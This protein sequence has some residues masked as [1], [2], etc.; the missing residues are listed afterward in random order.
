VN[1]FDCNKPNGFVV[2]AGQLDYSSRQLPTRIIVKDG[3]HAGLPTG[4]ALAGLNLILVNG[5]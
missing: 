5:T 2:K 1:D 3:Q 4:A